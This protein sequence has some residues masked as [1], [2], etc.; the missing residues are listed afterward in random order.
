MFTYDIAYL[1]PT[2]RLRSIRIMTEHM[3]V[4]G[5]QWTISRQYIYIYIYIYLYICTF[6]YI[7]IYIYIYP[8][9]FISIDMSI[10]N[11]L[12]Q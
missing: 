1:L 12:S 2:E 4:W 9:A 8:Y 3:C 6:I 11:T 10:F 5:N 7:Y